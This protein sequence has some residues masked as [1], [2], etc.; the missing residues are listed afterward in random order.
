LNDSNPGFKSLK[1][2]I[3]SARLLQLGLVFESNLNFNQIF[4]LISHHM[5]QAVPDIGTVSSG[6]SSLCDDC[7]VGN[8][9]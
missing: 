3:R 2:V 5:H 4:P 9:V 8:S 6:C 7:W 1:P